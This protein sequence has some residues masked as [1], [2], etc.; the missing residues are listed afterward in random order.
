MD[1]FIRVL[2][3]EPTIIVEEL[4]TSK[5]PPLKAFTNFLNYELVDGKSS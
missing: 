3:V 4:Y 1:K 2:S 5:D